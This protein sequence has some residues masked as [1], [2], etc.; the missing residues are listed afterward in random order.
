MFSLELQWPSLEHHQ[1]ETRI[2]MM[3]RADNK[4]LL[5]KPEKYYVKPK[6]RITRQYY[7]IKCTLLTP[8]SNSCKFSFSARSIP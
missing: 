6:L 8:A 2:T 4:I 7:P 1:N 5:P 3:Y